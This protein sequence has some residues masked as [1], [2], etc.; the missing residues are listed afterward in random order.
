MKITEKEFW[1]STPAKI[2]LLY[3]KYLDEQENWEIRFAKLEQTISIQYVDPGDPSKGR[4]PGKVPPMHKF[5]L[6][7][8]KF[9]NWGLDSN[10]RNYSLWGAE[11]NIEDWRS[12]TRT[13]PKQEGIPQWAA[14]ILEKSSQP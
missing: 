6:H 8:R 3:D 13:R 7:R 12:Y 2:Y 1:Q 14:S 10:R 9:R 11:A 5:M 4:P